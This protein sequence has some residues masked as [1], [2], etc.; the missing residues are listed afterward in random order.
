M[1]APVLCAALASDEAQP[2]T[3]AM[4]ITKSINGDTLVLAIAGRLD[5]TTSSQ[6]SSELNTTY[7]E[8][9]Y[10]L[11]FDLSQLDY[12]SSAGV[13]ALLMWA[14]RAAASG[15]SVEITGAAGLVEDVLRMT[16]L[17]AIV[18]NA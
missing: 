7:A 3:T 18:R 16:G 14:K 10:N 1:S 8:K 4:T 5:T 11:V 17:S 15:S 13:G 6:L 9:A 12:I 2:G